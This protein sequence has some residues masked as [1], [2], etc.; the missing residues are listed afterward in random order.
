MKLTIKITPEMRRRLAQAEHIELEVPDCEA[1]D[2]TFSPEMQR[3]VNDLEIGIRARN[4]L[5]N[6]GITRIGDLV[7]LT[8][9]SLLHLP[10]FG[11][12]CLRE[13]T[14]A[15]NQRG[16]ALG[17]T[18]PTTAERFPLI[19]AQRNQLLAAA[20]GAISRRAADVVIIRHSLWELDDVVS[21]VKNGGL[22]PFGPYAVNNRDAHRA[23]KPAQTAAAAPAPG[24]MGL[25]CVREGEIEGIKLGQTFEVLAEDDRNWEIEASGERYQVSKQTSQIRGC[26]DS[27]WFTT[28]KQGDKA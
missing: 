25:T 3:P 27:P 23:L 28:S 6:E 15:L 24:P 20:E 5:L 10:G 22:C 8:P 14:D 11:K 2:E 1:P 21:S 16:L 7:Q 17:M 18:Q 26:W 9:Y 4:S 19:L 12:R 13:V